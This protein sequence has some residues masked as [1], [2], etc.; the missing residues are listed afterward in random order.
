MKRSPKQIVLRRWDRI[1]KNLERLLKRVESTASPQLKAEI[2]ER[3]A[4]F[5]DL[6]K[7]DHGSS[8]DTR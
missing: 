6:Q 8:S 2:S 5:I 1:Q 7:L 3:I 4:Y